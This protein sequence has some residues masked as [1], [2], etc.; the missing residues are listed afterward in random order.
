MAGRTCEEDIRK[1]ENF[2]FTSAGGAE[3]I[4]D[5][6]CTRLMWLRSAA[7]CGELSGYFLT[8][9]NLQKCQIYYIVYLWNL[10]EFNLYFL[11]L[12]FSRCL[13]LLDRRIRIH[14]TYVRMTNLTN[15]KRKM[16]F[17]FSF[18]T[19]LPFPE[20]PEWLKVITLFQNY[21]GACPNAPRTLFDRPDCTSCL[22][23]PSP[24][25]P[26]PQPSASGSAPGVQPGQTT[27][28]QRDCGWK[29]FTADI[30]LAF[31]T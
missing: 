12:A 30:P 22:Q 6:F 15:W 20:C 4:F 29:D 8:F 26:N 1:I 2:P 21:S 24:P 11:F 10:F 13:L 16:F 23:W 3:R 9:F 5:F 18:F 27:F 7:R 14:R 31:S 19:F 25:E 28:L 17:P